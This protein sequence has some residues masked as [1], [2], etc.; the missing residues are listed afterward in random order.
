MEQTGSLSHI[1]KQDVFQ[2]FFCD[3]VSGCRVGGWGIYWIMYRCL[4]CVLTTEWI[5][6]DP[7][8]GNKLIFLSP[9][10]RCVCGPE[11]CG[12]RD[13]DNLNILTHMLT[14][15]KIV[16]PSLELTTH[17]GSLDLTECTHGAFGAHCSRVFVFFN[18]MHSY[19]K[20]EVLLR[21]SLS[22]LNKRKNILL[23]R[24]WPLTTDVRSAG[25]PLT[26]L[27][28]RWDPTTTKTFKVV[29]I[30]MQRALDQW[31]G[32]HIHWQPHY[33]SSAAVP[34]IVF[35]VLGI[36]RVPLQALMSLVCVG[37]SA[38]HQC[39]GCLP[40]AWDQR[41]HRDLDLGHPAWEQ[42]EATAKGCHT[43]LELT[44]GSFMQS[45]TFLKLIFFFLLL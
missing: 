1:E 42:S 31:S 16:P 32:W 34:Q 43:K 40:A 6:N 9:T 2:S 11:M 35:Q 38:C 15:L 13:W 25:A 27:T 14:H 33:Y 37:L 20:M 30:D 17:N 12:R 24:H 23:Q 39:T 4:G 45:K 26:H 28:D 21:S 44:V 36:S 8:T 5:M 19:V 10:S 18:H 29:V 41:G 3:M 7:V 22:T